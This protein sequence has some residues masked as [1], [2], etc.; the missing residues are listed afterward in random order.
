MLGKLGSLLNRDVAALV[1]DAG[2]VLNT[3]VGTLAK[4]AGRVLNADLGDLLRSPLSPPDDVAAPVPSG[5]SAVPR[6]PGEV[7]VQP[8]V[9][10]QVAAAPV[11]PRFDPDATLQLRPSAPASASENFNPDATLQLRPAAR[12]AAGAAESQ[13]VPTLADALVSRGD[14]LVPQGTSLMNLLPYDAGE[15]ARP[16]ATPAGELTSDPVSAVYRGGG[17]TIA[18]KLVQCWDAD[19]AREH[20]DDLKAL[21]GAAVRVGADGSWALGQTNQGTV[22][23]WNR[24]TY[25][26]SATSPK[27]TAPLA[28]FLSVFPY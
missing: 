3:D 16:H 11:A 7:P 25:A 23:A 9:D 10:T 17:D 27:G 19:E 21:A 8:A 22:F 14:R 4:G 24:D 5:D 12:A 2:K 13:P 1:K 28:K 20:L 15:F 6:V 18:L 26:F